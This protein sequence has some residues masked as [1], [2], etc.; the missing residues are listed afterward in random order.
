MHSIDTSYTIIIIVYCGLPDFHNECMHARAIMSVRLCMCMHVH[1]YVCVCVYMC[2]YVCVFVYVHSCTYVHVCV[3][4][5]V[6][7]CEN[8]DNT[9]SFLGITPVIKLKYKL[10]IALPKQEC[11]SSASV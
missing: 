3:C 5:C 1:V 11:A 9:N 2:N 4:M 6:D 8:Y 7:V 10:V